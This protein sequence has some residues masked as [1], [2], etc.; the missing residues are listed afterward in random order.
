M[1]TALRKCRKCSVEANTAEELNL[2]VKSSRL[3]HGRN[4]IC[5]KCNQIHQNKTRTYDTRKKSRVKI[6]YGISVEE[7]D[8]CM[9]TSDVCQ[10]CSKTTDLCYDHDHN[11]M[12]FR[13]VLCRQCNGAIGQLGD[14]LQGIAKA[15]K[16]LGGDL[17]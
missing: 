6:Y 13:G 5:K 3:P 15:Y 2:F 17:S 7:Y 16:Y 8:K 4:T 14:N 1:K 10:I 9:A 11:T 12:E